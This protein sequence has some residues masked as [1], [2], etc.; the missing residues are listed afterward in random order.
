MHTP[1]ILWFRADCS[2]DPAE[3]SLLVLHPT[4]LARQITLLT[5]EFIRETTLEDLKSSKTPRAQMFTNFC[6]RSIFYLQATLVLTKS[7]K[8]STLYS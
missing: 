2:T 3:Y 6:E 1:E 5:H 4:E 7:L 8:V